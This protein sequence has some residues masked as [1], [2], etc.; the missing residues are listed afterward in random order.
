MNRSQAIREMVEGLTWGLGIVV[1]AL[2]ATTARKLGYV[3]AETV[4][5]LVIGANGLMVAWY[6][7]RLPKV[8]VPNAQARK[9][10][11]VAG[12]AMVLSG[13]TYAGL[14]AFAPMPAATVGGV[15][16]ILGGMVVTL[17]YCLS[18]RHKPEAA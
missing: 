1:V 10:R 17:A 14:W 3:D 16:A 11:R 18:L 5:R 4:Q 2:A 13:L 12:W 9:A 8:F 7:N 15:A 6:G